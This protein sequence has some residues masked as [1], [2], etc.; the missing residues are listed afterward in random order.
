MLSTGVIVIGGLIIVLMV[1]ARLFLVSPKRVRTG[2][3]A[4]R[5]AAPRLADPTRGFRDPF[6]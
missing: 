5:R 1:L 2:K 4:G 6:R 3:R